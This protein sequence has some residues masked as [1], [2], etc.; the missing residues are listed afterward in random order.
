MSQ[1]DQELYIQENKTQHYK[2]DFNFLNEHKG[3][4]PGKIH[5]VVAPTHSGKSTLTRS[6]IWD[7][8]INNEYQR[9]FLWLSEESAED[10]KTEMA[11]LGLPPECSIRIFIVSE[12]DIQGDITKKKM[13]F[14]ETLNELMPDIVFFD[15]VTTS[16]FYMGQRPEAQGSFANYLKTKC[17][18]EGAPFV[19]IA[20][21]G[22][23]TGMNKRL[24]ELNHIRGGKDIV[25]ITEFA[26]VLQRFRVV[27]PMT[28][29]EIYFPT[30][31]LEKHRGYVCDNLLFKLRFNP[32]TVSFQQDKA[33]PWSAFKEAFKEQLTL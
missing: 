29:K 19:I 13:L 7:F 15:N 9:V 1:V 32:K 8:L 21:S 6:L 11:K 14:A 27:D 30:I 26:Y 17:N 33:I 4:R 23:D 2:S 31:R 28:N 20:H 5:T 24:I 10:F 22:S 18:Q 12:Q 25:N 3:W 16:I